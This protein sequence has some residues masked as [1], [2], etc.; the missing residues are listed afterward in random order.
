MD[1]IDLRS[2]TVTWPTAQMIEAMAKA[3]VGDDVYGDD[4]TVN[5]LQEMAAAAAGKEASLFVPSGTFGNQLAILTHTR[6]GDEMITGEGNHIV[7]H[8]VGAPAFIAG[9]QLRTV[10]DFHGRL[11]LDEV[12][13]LIREEDIH[14]PRTGLIC[15]EN[16]HSD[17]TVLGLDEMESLYRLGAGRG[18]PV[19][20][21]GAR[22]FNAAHCLGA[23][24]RDIAAHCDSVMFCLSKGLCCP[25]GSMLCGEQE[26]INRAKKFRKLLGGGLRQAGYIAA[27]GIIALEKMVSKLGADHENAKYLARLLGD[28]D[29]IQ[30]ETDRLDINMVF[31][32]IEAEGFNQDGFTGF[33][34]ENGIKINPVM[35]GFYRLV[36][37]YWI[38]KDD[39][40]IT[41]EKIR[42]YLERKER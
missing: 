4:P 8:E 5:R 18:I 41:V 33:L 30:V 1:S 12:A 15:T 23:D 32:R 35:D 7:Q 25:V 3:R 42:E 27:C 40:D 2:D 36:T 22:I 20:L 24:A 39:I 26:F 9:V 13:S 10:K 29:G 38:K 28:V 16:A 21:D 37:H 31:F 17:G 34:L 14:H 11:D 6:R 19:H